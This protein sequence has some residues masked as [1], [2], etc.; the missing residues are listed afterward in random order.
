MGNSATPDPQRPPSSRDRSD[1]PHLALRESSPLGQAPTPIVQSRKWH[2][3]GSLPHG[4]ERPE[5]PDPDPVFPLDGHH[6]AGADGNAESLADVLEQ[7][8]HPAAVVG[9]LLDAAV[10]Q[11]LEL[12]HLP[13]E[14]S[15]CLH[16]PDPGRPEVPHRASTWVSTLDTRAE[17]ATFAQC[18]RL[19]PPMLL[20]VATS[21]ESRRRAPSRIESASASWESS[22]AYPLP[23]THRRRPRYHS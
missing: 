10:E 4:S 20:I 13:A 9:G 6:V 18:R 22:T 16:A 23:L 7:A 15:R 2:A 19:D 11:L 17:R 12:I 1:T 8:K 21:A 3:R 14:P 5:H